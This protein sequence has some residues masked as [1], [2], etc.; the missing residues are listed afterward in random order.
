[1]VI[2]SKSIMKPSTLKEKMEK[3]KGKEKTINRKKKMNQGV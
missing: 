3:L 2:N 1:M